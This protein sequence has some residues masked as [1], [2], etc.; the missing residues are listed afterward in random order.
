MGIFSALPAFVK[1]IHRSQVD[2]PHKNQWRGASMFSLGCAWANGWANNEAAGD[3][4]QHRAD[5][6]VIVMLYVYNAL[7]HII[8]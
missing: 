7:T 8:I 4:R 2:S 6:D 1:G 3:L 5:Y